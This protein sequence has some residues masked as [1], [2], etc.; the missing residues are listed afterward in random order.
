MGFGNPR[1][2]FRP[3]A[4]RLSAVIS[5]TTDLAKIEGAASVRLI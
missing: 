1:P 2:F 5:S 4:Q 3:I